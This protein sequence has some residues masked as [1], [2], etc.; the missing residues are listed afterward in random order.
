MLK[1]IRRFVLPFFLICIITGNL[2]GIASLCAGFPF[3]F[4]V[5]Y[6]VPKISQNKMLQS[7]TLGVAGV[8]VSMTFM[9]VF[10]IYSTKT[11]LVPSLA[12]FCMCFMYFRVFTKTPK[13]KH[14]VFRFFSMF[15]VIIT[16]MYI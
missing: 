4:P 10:E 8:I 1:S 2:S 11:W 12:G 13:E 15:F 7:A 9:C 3:V 14:A 5:L 16:C 6:D